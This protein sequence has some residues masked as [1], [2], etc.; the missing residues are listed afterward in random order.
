[1]TLLDHFTTDDM[2]VRTWTVV[3]VVG[4][5]ALMW[6]VGETIFIHKK[7]KQVPKGVT[8]LKIVHKCYGSNEASHDL[9]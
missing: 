2:S 6:F 4:T 7:A 5:L 3:V 1:M 9:W 8:L